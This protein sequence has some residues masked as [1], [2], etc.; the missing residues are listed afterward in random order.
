MLQER[1]AGLG[2]K[3]QIHFLEEMLSTWRV[4]S[5]SLF[6][7]KGNVCGSSSEEVCSVFS[8]LSLSTSR[9]RWPLHPDPHLQGSTLSS[10]FCRTLTLPFSGISLAPSG[11]SEF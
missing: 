6:P 8:L 5:P 7:R 9:T 1:E 11:S 3:M 4:P 2:G 10:V